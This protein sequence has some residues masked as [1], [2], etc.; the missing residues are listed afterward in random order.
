MLLALAASVIGVADAAAPGRNG[1]IL[2]ATDASPILDRSVIY[3]TDLSGNGARAVYRSAARRTHRAGDVAVSPAGD[4][5][6]FVDD[7][8]YIVDLRTGARRAI[9]ESVFFS[10]PKWSPDGTMLAFV[11]LPDDN[12]PALIRT[13]R[14]DGTDLRLRA[15]GFEPSWTKD[16][17]RLIFIGDVAGRFERE[18]RSLDLATEK[19]TALLPV[20]F[21]T[22][23]M[24][25]S[26]DGESV[27]Y[28][29]SYSGRSYATFVA[30]L[31]GGVVRKISEAGGRPV[32]S[33]DGK[34]IAQVRGNTLTIADPARDGV[35]AAFRGDNLHSPPAWS[36]DGAVVAVATDPFG[37]PSPSRVHFV[38]L[39][40][41]RTRTFTR[42]EGGIGPPVWVGRGRLV[43]PAF[44]RG[45]DLDVVVDRGI[46]PA[47]LGG[48]P[49]R[50]YQPTVSPD[51]RM[52]AHVSGN[53]GEGSILVTPIRGGRSRRVAGGYSPAWSPDATTL[54]FVS[55]AAVYVVSAHGRERPRKLL[56]LAYSP[57]W[58]PDGRELAVSRSDGVH[59]VDVDRKRPPRRLRT[60]REIGDL[61]WSPDGRWIVYDSCCDSRPLHVIPADGTGASRP[62]TRFARSEVSEPAWS[63]DGR[64]ILAT[65]KT[66]DAHNRDETSVYSI[67]F[68]RRTPVRLQDAE[69]LTPVDSTERTPAWQPVCTIE[70]TSGPDVLRG[71]AGADVICGFGG[72]D[73]IRAGAGADVVIG[74][75]G[76]DRIDGGR[77]ADRL[78]G[79]YGDDAL[80]GRDGSVDVLDGGPGRD[81][82]RA[83]KR[84]LLRP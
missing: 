63:P 59:I 50:D 68:G 65:V 37:Y 17:S 20:S 52:V 13:V 53:G 42:A 36:P 39:D 44:A 73:T 26:P 21:E 3:L 47:V 15:R 64:T 14:A 54:A 81:S 22:T 29:V 55:E 1:A 23:T 43:W 28:V 67:P 82:A 83:D 32:W 30:R 7:R 18:V 51:G 24:S 40:G 62:L 72:D 58:S 49:L 79:A 45:N 34:S 46:S 6:A 12:G 4:R 61:D 25:L 66:Y 16:G 77:G 33:P 31:A 10:S 19:E 84:D 69:R 8:L 48:S 60:Q 56:D 78:F 71:T 75:D 74:G 41:G 70:G 76:D 2:Y 38:R 80:L 27:V 57:A 9:A 5:I 11:G 35:R